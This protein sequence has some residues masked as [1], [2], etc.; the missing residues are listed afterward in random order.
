MGRLVGG[1]QSMEYE[2]LAVD[3]WLTGKI[4]EVQ[5]DEHRTYK[6][7]DKESGEWSEKESPHV[8]LKLKIDGYKWPHYSRWMKCSTN[9]KSNFYSKYLK[10]LCPEYDCEDK[11]IDI[12]KLVGVKCKTMWENNDEYQNITS[13]RGLEP[14]LNI[15]ASGEEITP[16]LPP[17]DVSENDG[18]MDVPF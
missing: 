2:K 14:T 6:S 5:Y 18:N 4:E 1:K 15:I 8:R 7:K 13:I 10:Y 16:G 11:V 17:E 12:D 9:G 3:E